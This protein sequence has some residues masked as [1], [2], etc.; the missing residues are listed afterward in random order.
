MPMTRVSATE[1]RH[2]T[3]AAVLPIVLLA[4]GLIAASVALDVPA[5]RALVLLLVAPVAEEIVFRAGVQDEMLRRG[6]APWVANFGT[7][8]A[9]TAA[10]LLLLGVQPQTALVILPA[11]LIGAAYNRTRSLR[12]CMALHMSFNA[13]WIA[14]HGMS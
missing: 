3:T 6:L 9:F 13:L 8:V 4:A 10:H 1:W 14:V 11:L 7:G 5:W 12:I 2:P